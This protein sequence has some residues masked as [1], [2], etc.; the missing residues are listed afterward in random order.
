MR[1][2]PK[3]LIIGTGSLRNYGCEAIIQGTYS[4]LNAYWPECTLFVASDDIEYDSDIFQG[5]ENIKFIPYRKRFTLFRLFKGILRRIGYGT[6]SPVRMQSNIVKR[7]DI[8]L[9]AGGD[10]YAES[11]E[12]TLYHILIDLLEM[13]RKAKKHNKFFVIWGASI[14]PFSNNNLKLIKEDLKRTDLQ[15]VREEISYNYLKSIGLDESKIFRVADPA[16][17]M[18]KSE[19][20]KY[21]LKRNNEIL[22]GLNISELSIIHA[23]SSI[24]EG[25][26]IMFSALDHLLQENFNYRFICIPHVVV[27][28]GGPQDDF[29]FMQKYLNYT[30]FRERIELISPGL[31]AKK[32]KKIISECDLLI[33]AR[34]HCC[35]AGVSSGVPTLFLTYSPKGIGMSR[36][37]YGNDNMW[38]S[39][40]EVNARILD[41]KVKSILLKGKEI[42]KHLLFKKSE[43][44]SDAVNGLNL[45]KNKFQE[46]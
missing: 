43:F 17:I 25:M 29:S 35:I 12:G 46:K 4:L 42:R 38:L 41:A 18:E 34:M 3:I 27:D 2:G 37:A 19:T 21:I 1:T 33:S 15:L 36:Y 5:M 9:S 40:K 16:F 11:P 32:T 20:T 28:K 7:Y 13:G 22:I 23:F 14:G 30:K 31:G 8:I 26:I 44:I 39:T 10:N 6:G 24:Q 45:V